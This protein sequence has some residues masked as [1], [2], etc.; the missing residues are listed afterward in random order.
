MLPELSVWLRPW[1]DNRDTGSDT[2]VTTTELPVSHILIIDQSDLTSTYRRWQRGPSDGD[3]ECCRMV[4]HVTTVSFQLAHSPN[5]TLLL[6]VLNGGLEPIFTEKYLVQCF[7]CDAYYYLQFG[8]IC[9]PPVMPVL[10]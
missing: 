3:Q 2:I 6:G 4:A 10:G 8:R 9:C 5:L 7:N 1:L